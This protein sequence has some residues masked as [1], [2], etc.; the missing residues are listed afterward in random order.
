MDEAF[1]HVWICQLLLDREPLSVAQAYCAR[2]RI[3]PPLAARHESARDSAQGRRQAAAKLRD[4]G[5]WV[6]QIRLRNARE[7]RR[8]LPPR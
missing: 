7:Q 2:Q 3:L 8:R 6:K 4:Y 1:Q 5:W